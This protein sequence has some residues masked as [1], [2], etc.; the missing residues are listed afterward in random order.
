MTTFPGRGERQIV[1]ASCQANPERIEYYRD[2][3]FAA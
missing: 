2:E 1:H 3:V